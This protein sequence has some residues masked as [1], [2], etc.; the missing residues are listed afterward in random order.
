[1]QT[2]PGFVA[3]S[4]PDACHGVLLRLQ[5]AAHSGEG[6]HTPAG[7]VIYGVVR[8]QS[9]ERA[10]MYVDLWCGSQ[11]HRRAARHA[12]RYPSASSPPGEGRSSAY[13]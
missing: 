11:Q 10:G 5:P 2:L 3:S 7:R 13:A 1:M 12:C 6:R 8:Q 9:M 4:P